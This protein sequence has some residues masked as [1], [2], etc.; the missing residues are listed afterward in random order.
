MEY[1]PSWETASR[2]DFQEI[3]T[4]Y[5]TW[6][7][8]SVY[9]T[10]RHWILSTI[11]PRSYRNTILNVSFHLRLG[12]FFSGFQIKILYTYPCVL[13][14]ASVSS[15][16]MRLPKSVPVYSWR[17]IIISGLKIVTKKAYMVVRCQRAA[18]CQHKMFLLS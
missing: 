13:H 3:F 18:G 15:S 2:S 5:R 6:R 1:S 17:K 8:I 16:L 11:Q 10:A 14:A 4:L 12:L 9:T 7:S